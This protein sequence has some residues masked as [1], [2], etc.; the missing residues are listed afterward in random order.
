MKLMK[1]N[2]CLRAVLIISA[3]LLYS[4]KTSRHNL[5]RSERWHYTGRSDIS[6]CA[7]KIYSIVSIINFHYMYD[8]EYIIIIKREK[9]VSYSVLLCA[10]ALLR[11]VGSMWRMWL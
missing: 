8:Q 2:Y 7:S 4:S 3:L 10:N 11:S 1:T 9:R 5:M 6:S